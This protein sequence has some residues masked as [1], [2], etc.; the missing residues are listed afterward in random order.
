MT[1][2]EASTCQNKVVKTNRVELADGLRLL[3][4]VGNEAELLLEKRTIP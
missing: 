1:L 4:K 2:T 3:E